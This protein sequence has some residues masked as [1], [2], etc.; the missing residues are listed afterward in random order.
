MWA[1][2]EYACLNSYYPGWRQVGNVEEEGQQK[3]NGYEKG[4]SLEC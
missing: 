4:V 3:M 2:S 1:E